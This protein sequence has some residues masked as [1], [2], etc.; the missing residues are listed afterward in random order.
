MDVE[1]AGVAADVAEL[2]V[3]VPREDLAA[4]AANELDAIGRGGV[5]R[6]HGADV[7][8]RHARGGRRRRRGARHA[9]LREAEEL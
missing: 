3:V 5:R 2:A 8:E 7:V 1:D 4:V 9:L 6:L